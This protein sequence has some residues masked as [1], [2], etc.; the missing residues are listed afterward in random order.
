MAIAS[1]AASYIVRLEQVNNLECLDGSH[2]KGD[3]GRPQASPILLQNAKESLRMSTLHLSSPLEHSD[4]LGDVLREN[5]LDTIEQQLDGNA[6]II[7]VTGPDG[8]GKTTLLRQFH[9]RHQSHSFALFLSSASRWAYSPTVM[10]DDLCEQLDRAFPSNIRPDHQIERRF[11]R[12]ITALQRRARSGGERF[13]FILDGLEEIPADDR[14][15][16]DELLSFMPFGVVGVR[17]LISGDP[18]SL[19]LSH[20]AKKQ[21][22]QFPVSYLGLPRLRRHGVYAAVASS[23]IRVCCSSNAAGVR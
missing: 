3:T 9:D 18:S 13:Y 19:S 6:T 5:L 23:L 20:T 4:D 15:S 21:L 22:R 11:A 7:A 14:S 2:V 10:L 16:R 1:E 12:L 8:V 17:C